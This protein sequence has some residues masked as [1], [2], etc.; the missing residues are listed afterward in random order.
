MKVDVD[1]IEFGDFKLKVV[2]DVDETVGGWKVHRNVWKDSE[3][4]ER[5]LDSKQLIEAATVD[6]AVQA[7]EADIKEM[8]QTVKGQRR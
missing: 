6:D 3:E 8:K 5:L 2:Y 7:I 1:L 4:C